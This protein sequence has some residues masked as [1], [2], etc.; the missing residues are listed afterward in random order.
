MPVF[1]ESLGCLDASYLYNGGETT[2]SIPVGERNDHSIDVQ[3]GGVGTFIVT[4]APA[5]A[6][7]VQYKFAIRSNDQSL[8]DQI[9]LLY[10]AV[11]R[12]DP[13]SRLLIGTP[14]LAR[15]SSSCLRYD[16]IMYVPRNVKK[17]HIQSHTPAHVQID[18]EAHLDLDDTY[19]TL[20]N[21]DKR[22]MIQP[23]ENLRS[24][25]LALEVHRGWI[26]G[27]ASIVNETS[28]STQRGDGVANVHLH[29]TVALDLANPE[30]VSLRTKSGG[31]RTDLYFENDKSFPHRP[32]KSTHSSSRSADIYLTYK[33]AEF[34]GKV[35]LGSSAFTVTGAKTYSKDSAWT[36][37]A[38][39]MDGKDEISISS[40]GWTGLY[41]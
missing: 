20:F 2:I 28:I 41:F 30:L 40:R 27:D 22:N 39:N 14:S 3:G 16:V 6:T 12:P 7:E 36:H 5:D 32:I 11:G 8:L 17:L 4:E 25:H 35:K 33:K 1:S 34:D 19:V 10:P 29:P 13:M 26:V 38:G 9:S 18:P 15:G 23:T 31:G 21:L 37:W 24:K